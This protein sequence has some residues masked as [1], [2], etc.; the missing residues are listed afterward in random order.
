MK[1][2][3][4]STHLNKYSRIITQ[5]KQNGSAQ[6]MLYALGLSRDDLNKPQVGIGTVWFEGNPC[7]SE[8]DQVSKHVKTSLKEKN[9][10]PMRFNTIGVSD[11]KTMGTDAMRYSLPS[12]ELIADSMEAI[13][14]A[15]HY[16]ASILIPGCDKNLPASAMALARI[17]RPGFIIYGGSM[18]PKYHL[19]KNK[20]ERLDIVSSFE[21][22]GKY[23]KGEITDDERQEIVENSCHNSCGA[24]SGFYTANTMSCILE[25][26]GLT[27]PNSSSN[28]SLSHDKLNECKDSGQVIYNLMKNDIKPLDIMTRESFLNA[29]KF[30]TLIGGS[31]N[32]VIHLLA[33]ARTAG[34]NLTLD[35]FKKYEDLPVLT[36]MKPHG[37][38]VMDDLNR[39]GGTS[40]LIKYLIDEGILNGDCM[41]VTSKTLK[42]NTI[43]Q[44]KINFDEG[45]I[46]PLESA[47]KKSSHI[48][49]L[50]GN[51]APNGS[52]SK[53]YSDEK[54][55]KGKA[56][57]FDNQEDMLK[58]LENGEITENNFVILRYQGES[59][60]CPE[61]LTPTSAL[62]GYFNARDKEN[63]I[64]PFATDGRFSGGSTG[65]LVAHLPDAFKDNSV[66]ALIEN[67]DFITI[68]IEKN[69]I[70][71]DVSE[72]EFKE[73]EK[74]VIKP[75]LKLDGYLRKYKKLVSDLQDGY[76]T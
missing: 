14:N 76:L 36:N 71:I 53:I 18:K 51:M 21:A 27:L 2:R 17:N 32:G 24:C 62:V 65:V 60:G 15:E 4:M 50:S 74:S 58:S 12:R 49:I 34:V 56:I 29:I 55:F 35:D 20:V 22:Y 52:V 5:A 64:P 46:L 68:D 25:V 11:G 10:L 67:D 61:M 28:M 23:I 30:L 45:I 16:D 38:Y 72:N 13:I 7:N 31:T 44:K 33:M 73:R 26:M 3:S 1:I 6:A 47:F 69:S 39:L 41:T 75:V 8:L 48:N 57:V 43:D 19:T 66:T 59:T 63:K 70:N 9:L 54:I 42:E 40:V 37:L